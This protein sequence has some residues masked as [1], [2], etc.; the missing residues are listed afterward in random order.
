M[1]ERIFQMGGH[2]LLAIECTAF[3]LFS[4]LS[5]FAFFLVCSFFSRDILH[6]GL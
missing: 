6:F 5:S 4:L 2:P 3:E 1:Y